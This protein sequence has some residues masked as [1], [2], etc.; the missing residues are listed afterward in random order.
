MAVATLYHCV[1]SSKVDIPLIAEG[2]ARVGLRPLFHDARQAIAER[3][4]PWALQSLTLPGSDVE[5][6]LSE[7]SARAVCVRL[8]QTQRVTSNMVVDILSLGES[9]SSLPQSLMDQF[10][11][12]LKPHSWLAQLGIDRLTAMAGSLS[13]N[14][15][16]LSNN[17]QRVK[18]RRL[19]RDD[20]RAVLSRIISTFGDNPTPRDALQ[21]LEASVDDDHLDEVL[22][23][24]EFMTKHFVIACNNCGTSHLTFEQAAAAESAVTSSEQ[25]CAQCGEQ[26]LEI[27]ETYAPAQPYVR[28]IKQGLWLEALAS[29]VIGKYAAQ[30]WSGQM[31]GSIEVDVVAVVDDVTVLVECKDTSFGQND[32]YVTAVK[33]QQVAADLV[34]V[35]NTRDVH[36]NVRME[37]A[38]IDETTPAR[39]FYLLNERT[40]AAIK[41]KLEAILRHLTA[42][43]AERW[44]RTPSSS[45]TVS[46]GQSSI[47]WSRYQIT[48]LVSD[49]VT[50]YGH[51]P[52]RTLLPP[53]LTAK[54]STVKL[55][56]SVE[57][58]G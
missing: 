35:V 57:P 23:D 40:A 54:R 10:P 1:P 58:T 39:T 43:P 5:V 20:A 7:D 12:P 55:G 13:P 26:A 47:D 49:A 2:L 14:G 41:S 56:E 6:F 16:I 36:D 19:Y 51:T 3:L 52:E 11:A 28:A 17:A 8:W 9:D 33:A 42:D 25:R 15:R 38:R 46:T 44:L 30:S 45:T 4:Q 18:I 21:Q 31:L 22:N 32:L 53:E 24:P 29:D 50:F 27:R 34:I 48:S 37:L